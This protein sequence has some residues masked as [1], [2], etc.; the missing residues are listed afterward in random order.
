MVPLKRARKTTCGAVAGMVLAMLAGHAKVVTL[1]LVLSK[2][3]R[4]EATFRYQDT[5]WR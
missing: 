3:N 1:V 2:M 5:V 4:Q